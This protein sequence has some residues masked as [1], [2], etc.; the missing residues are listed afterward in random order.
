MEREML[1]FKA[2]LKENGYSKFEAEEGENDDLLISLAQAVWYGE[3]ILRGGK[4]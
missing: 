2:E 3:E 4:L 1:A